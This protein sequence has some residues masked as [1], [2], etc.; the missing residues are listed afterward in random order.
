M[1]Q[2]PRTP[3]NLAREHWRLKRRLTCKLLLIWLATTF[4]T[5][6][7]A[8]ALDTLSIF[9]WPVSFYLAAQ[10]MGLIYLALVYVY[11][12]RMAILEAQ[13]KAAVDAAPPASYPDTDSHHAG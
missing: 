8:R 5:V 1:N 9:G 12:R 4:I 10:G 3:G 13:L 7:F 11:T 6:Y 2:P